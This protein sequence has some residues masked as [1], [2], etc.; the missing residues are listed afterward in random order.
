MNRKNRTLRAGAFAAAV[1]LIAAVLAG[2]AAPSVS[3]QTRDGFYLD[4]YVRVSIYDRGDCTE[5]LDGAMALCAEYDTLFGRE[6]SGSDVRRVNEANGE[7]VEVDSRTAELAALG[8][9]Y[10][11]L[12]E[13]RFD[14]TCGAVTELWDFSGETAALPD[15]GTLEAAL[16]TV[17]AENLQCTEHSVTME[18]G[19][20][21]DLGGIAKGYIA[22]RIAE[23]LR[24]SGVESALIDLGGNICAVGGKS[25]SEPFRV[26]VQ[27]PYDENDYLAVVRAR[28]MS[29]VTAGKYERGFEL[30]G[31]RYHH[32]LDLSTGMPSESGVCAATVISPL[33]VSGDALST[34]C[35]LL[36]AE[37]ALA[38][39]ESIPDT[40]AILSLDSGETL[41]TSGAKAFL[42]N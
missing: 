2:C 26:A 13:G 16:T 29:V 5:L 6:S 8:A 22:D 39:I 35:V 36:G 40:E 24:D 17:G 7:E 27:S 23:Y 41:Y 11:A 9:E 34:S 18:N 1:L 38:L 33:S 14:V 10:S 12:T 25:T 3:P 4:T 21:L 37:E 30:D 31:V 28:D 42:E 19:A 15:A 20:K 32:I